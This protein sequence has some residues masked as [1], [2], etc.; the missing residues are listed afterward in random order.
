MAIVTTLFASQVSYANVYD[1]GTLAPTEVFSEES[2]NLGLIAKFTDY[3]TFTITSD[4]T[5]LFGS[6]PDAKTITGGLKEIINI[7]HVNL[8]AGVI[9]ESTRVKYDL[10]KSN[11]GFSFKNISAGAYYFTVNGKQ[12]G[13][14]NGIYTFNLAVLQTLTTTP[15]VATAVPE[16][17]TY[18]MMI[19][20]LGLIGFA[21]GRKQ[22]N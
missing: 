14:G 11:E 13:S 6:V 19:A 1:L 2:G 17:E 22:K 5:T 3:Y 7:K 8:Y 12:R 4:T 16:T 9:G 15:P 21:I 18:S 20:G 10:D